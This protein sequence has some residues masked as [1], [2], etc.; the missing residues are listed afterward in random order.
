MNETENT[1]SQPQFEGEDEIDLIALIKKVWDGRKS[2]I[3]TTVIFIFILT[4][5]ILF[6][7][8]L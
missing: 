3:K 4:Y 6:E 5:K 8:L 2:I 1:S 7:N